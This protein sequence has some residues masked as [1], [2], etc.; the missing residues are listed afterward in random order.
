MIITSTGR[1][2]PWQV[3]L[4]Y[5]YV[6]HTSSHRSFSSNSIGFT[7]QDKSLLFSPW[8]RIDKSRRLYNNRYLQE[9]NKR[10]INLTSPKGHWGWELVNSI[11]SNLGFGL[12]FKQ[13]TYTPS[14]Q[15]YVQF[16]DDILVVKVVSRRF[17]AA[18]AVVIRQLPKYIVVVVALREEWKKVSFRRI[19][20]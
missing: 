16:C 18:A 3:Y 2:G 12:L 1:V 7:I 20:K 9:I 6:L 11:Q 19:E 5:K 10:F 15:N 8:F 13:T 17:A 4:Y 14:I